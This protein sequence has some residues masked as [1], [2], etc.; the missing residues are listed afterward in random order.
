MTETAPREADLSLP[1]LNAKLVRIL[2]RQRVDYR[3][4]VRHGRMKQSAAEAAEIELNE[5]ARL[6][7]VWSDHAP[8]LRAR[9]PEIAAA[10]KVRLA[11]DADAE[12]AKAR[13]LADLTTR[14]PASTPASPAPPSVAD[15]R[16]DTAPNTAP[17]DI[18]NHPAVVATLAALPGARI[19]HVQPIAPD[20]S[21]EDTPA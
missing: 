7:Q 20:P 21:P 3:D 14:P 8:E 9:W 11:A 2:K 5:L 1:A 16:S 19:A 6:F 4:L 12:V 17:D 13:R 15:L 10:R 18:A